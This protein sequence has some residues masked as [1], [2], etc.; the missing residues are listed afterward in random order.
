LIRNI[1]NLHYEWVEWDKKNNSQNEMICFTIREIESV[2]EC[3]K[4][5]EDEYDV[6]MTVYGGRYK[7][8]D[9]EKLK[10]LINGYRINKKNKEEIKKIAKTFEYCYINNSLLEVVN[11]ILISLRNNQNVILLGNNESGLTQIAEW[12][13]I[14]FNKINIEKGVNLNICYCTKNLECTELIGSQKLISE[15]GKDELRFEPGFLYNSIDEGSCIV[16][17][18]INEAPSRVIERL[19]GLLDKKNNEEEK[20]FEVQEN[21]KNPKLKIHRNFRI[22]ATSNF[23]KINQI[24]PAFV[25]RF[26]VITLEDQISFKEIKGIKKLI[27]ILAN[28][29]QKE[30]YKNNKNIN[31]NL[32]NNNVKHIFEKKKKKKKNKKKKKI[33]KKN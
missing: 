21:T 19:N 6:I 16:L 13:A 4:N 32:K 8:N 26:Q 30:Y 18:N 24:S 1:V 33:I 27:Q 9:K 14:Y 20:Y 5:E 29:Y 23:D 10:Q 7:K 22:I 11:S 15:N 2:I 25:N 12:C 31:K 17:D 28:K 3:L